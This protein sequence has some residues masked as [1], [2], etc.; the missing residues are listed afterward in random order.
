MWTSL[1]LHPCVGEE[2][3]LQGRG[4]QKRVSALAREAEMNFRLRHIF[5][6]DSSSHAFCREKAATASRIALCP[7]SLS[8]LICCKQSALTATTPK[9]GLDRRASNLLLLLSQPLN[10]MS[11][12]VTHKQIWE[13]TWRTARCSVQMWTGK[14]KKKKKKTAPGWKRPASSPILPCWGKM[15]FPQHSATKKPDHCPHVFH[16]Q[17]EIP[18]INAR[19]FFFPSILLLTRTC[20]AK[21]SWGGCC[22]S[23][24]GSVTRWLYNEKHRPREAGTTHFFFPPQKF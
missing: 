8:S 14:V 15:C 3:R 1:P 23:H 13:Q 12:R 20:S 2:E 17:V 5:S 6:L 19:S 18:A 22:S 10:T 21:P 7:A 9:T 16:Q 4:Q 11:V 24:V